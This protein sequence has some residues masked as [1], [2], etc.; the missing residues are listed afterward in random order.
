MTSILQW[1]KSAFERWFA[2]D[3]A[4]TPQHGWLLPATVQMRDERTVEDIRRR[5]VGCR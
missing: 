1:A 5:E 3:V 2:P 4:L